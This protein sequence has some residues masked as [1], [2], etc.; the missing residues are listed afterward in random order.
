MKQ[1]SIVG[2]GYIGL[3][4]AI[5]A[6]QNGYK[7]SGF[8]IDKQKVE[9]INTGD[10]TIVE[11]EI[12]QRL[13]KVLQD[14][15]FSATTKLKRA[16]CF[17]I[18][19]PT[20]FFQEN[21]VSDLSYVFD[22]AKRICSVINPGNL[23]ILEST[24][25]VGTTSKVAQLIAEKSGL[26]LGIDLFVAH[27]PE[28]VL[29]GKIFEELVCN[30]R[31]IG[32]V[33]SGSAKLA[34]NFYSKFVKGKITFT[35]DKTAEMVKLVENSSRDVAI[36]FANQ[37]ASMCNKAGLNP[38]EVIEFA[39]NH[40]RVNILNPGCG[41]G[42]H[43]IAVD[44]WFL[45]E[46]F[47]Q[48]SELLKTARHI[49]DM[50]PDHIIKNVIK[51]VAAIKLEKKAKPNVLVLGLTFKPDVDD[52]RN[53]PALQIAM[54]LNKKSKTLNLAVCEPNILSDK[55]KKIGFENIMGLLQGVSWA[56]IIIILVNHKA[57][58][59]LKDLDVKDKVVLDTCGL[60]Y[61]KRRDDF[62]FFAKSEKIH[63]DVI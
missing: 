49:N 35:D 59:P 34:K 51:K 15:S 24:V 45:I 50:R 58:I 33:C 43:C 27:C 9:K 26:K 17:I 14:K 2:L 61:K 63:V 39:N 30:D 53:S 21:K 38:H 60:L 31:I 62:V 18:S 6:A 37:V 52:L 5:V 3:P 40:P 29:P 20:P 48:N 56:D 11:P 41:V 57:F 8:D 42:G 10:P 32:A 13:Y 4:T 44:P 16:D 7:V 36:A 22:A 12:I 19:V 46:T 1:I 28:R 47:P 23:V 25:P 55:L 54:A